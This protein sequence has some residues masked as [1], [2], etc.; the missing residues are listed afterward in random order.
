MPENP[1]SDSM[2]AQDVSEAAPGRGVSAISEMRSTSYWKYVI[3]V[4]SVVIQV[5]VGGLYAW[6]SFVP[7]LRES[8]ALN[9]TQTQLIFG[10]LI[11]VFTVAMVFAGRLLNNHKPSMIAGTG[12]ILFGL[13]YLIA[14]YSNG[15]FLTLVAGISLLAGAGT[16]FCYV[17]PL[18]M[19]AQWFPNQK[20]LATGIA[21]AGF[22]G[23]AVLLSVLAEQFLADGMD[24][25]AVFRLIGIG[26]A[27]II[28]LA[29]FSLR[30]PTSHAQTSTHR[31]VRF[32]SLMRDQFAR[33]LFVGMFS[34]T[35]AG[36]AVVGNLK[37]LALSNN[38]TAASAAGAISAFAVGNAIGR[39]TWGWIADRIGVC[40]IPLSLFT[41]TAALSLLV[42]SPKGLMWFVASAALIG[43]GF[44]ACF[45]VYAAQVASRYGPSQIASVY[46][47]IFLAYGLSGILGPLAGGWLYDTTASFTPGLLICI[48]VTASGAFVSR[49]Y[50]AAKV[51]RC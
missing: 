4:A 24:V 9:S 33:V 36:L 8:F 48:F 23:G 32:R 29:S 20:G 13:G 11:G 26:Y 41:L 17:C 47:A 45:V 25:L 22:G 34:G 31:A 10:V 40:V 49:S 16:G 7:A 18:A 51:A 37:P 6:S 19:C 5:C 21:V 38:L 35:F 30:F 2:P 15:A 12:G 42:L 27:V 3:L 44:G 28:I 39:I 14:S 1:G 46:P 50:L 43:F